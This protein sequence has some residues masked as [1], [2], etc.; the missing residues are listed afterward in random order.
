MAF[1]QCS[2]F[3]LWLHLVDSSST[4]TGSM[5]PM[6]ANMLA[7][8]LLLLH[9]AAQSAQKHKTEEAKLKP[10]VALSFLLSVMP[11]CTCV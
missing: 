4:L 6:V 1:P 7:S 2:Q 9:V 10:P 8:L 3:N 11:G 5:V